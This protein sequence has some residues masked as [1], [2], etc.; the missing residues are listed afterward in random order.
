MEVVPLQHWGWLWLWEFGPR[1]QIFPGRE[2]RVS[3]ALKTL[4]RAGPVI[5]LSH[6]SRVRPVRPSHQGLGLGPPPWGPT[7]A[8]VSVWEQTS[9]CHSRSCTMLGARSHREVL[10]Q[11]VG[12]PPA[13]ARAGHSEED[14]ETGR[15]MLSVMQD[16]TG[17]GL[18][19]EL[20]S[21][22]QGGSRTAHPPVCG[23]HFP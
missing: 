14:T 9:A 1:L 3:R 2:A 10:Q 19:T 21:L 5:I 20:P 13:R 16:G 4:Q 12:E 6:H 15:R 11:V 22:S 18:A 17:K 23:R 8:M 7:A